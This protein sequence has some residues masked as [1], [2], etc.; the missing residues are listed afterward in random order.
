[1]LALCPRIFRGQAS[2]VQMSLDVSCRTE[3]LLTPVMV[4]HQTDN[5]LH[6]NE[7]AVSLQFKQNIVRT[8]SRLQAGAGRRMGEERGDLQQ[9]PA[10]DSHRDHG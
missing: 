5:I 7:T 9:S 4:R 6:S 1:M 2:A 8:F 3:T 10:L